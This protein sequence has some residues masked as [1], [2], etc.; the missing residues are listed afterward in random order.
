[1]ALEAHGAGYFA[2]QGRPHVLLLLLT[3]E[4]KTSAHATPAFAPLSV[5]RPT[6]KSSRDH[7]RSML[8]PRSLVWLSEPATHLPNILLN[9]LSVVSTRTGL[10]LAMFTTSRGRRYTR[11]LGLTAM[12]LA[13]RN[14][15]VQV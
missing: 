14:M 6:V 5:W 3:L 1:M 9:R 2:P 13:T 15:N 7:V 4:C 12:T 11:S 8:S 10:H